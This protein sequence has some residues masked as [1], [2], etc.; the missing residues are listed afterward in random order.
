MWEM[1]QVCHTTL[2][3]V[4]IDFVVSFVEQSSYS[5]CL[6]FIKQEQKK[7]LQ[8]GAIQTSLKFISQGFSRQ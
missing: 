1:A 4:L 2:F 6:C 7:A 3:L 8:N 5:K